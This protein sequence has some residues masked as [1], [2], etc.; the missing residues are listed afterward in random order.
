VRLDSHHHFWRYDAAE[1]GW[2]DAPMA[3]IRRDFLPD[4]LRVVAAGAGVDGAITVQARQSLAET[5][6]L[7]ELAAGDEF[8]RGVVGWV[9]LRSPMLSGQLERFA[10]EPKFRGVRHVVQGEPDEAFILGEAFNRGVA[11]LRAHRLVYDILIFARHL[12]NTLRFVDRHPDQVFV[13][14]HLAKP[15]IRGGG[16]GFWREQLRELARRPNVFCKASGL[17]T[18]ADY[19]TWTE[20]QLRP[21]FEAAVEAFGPR[22]LMAGSDWPVCLVACDYVRWWCILESWTA[23]WSD[24]ERARFFGGTAHEAYS[25]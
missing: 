17:V 25:L 2:I 3:A 1:F 24:A 21:Y 11:Q 22:R 5:E 19:H 9:D 10:A 14:D 12:P 4:D 13:V 8:I 6:W 20:A 18:E 23:S 16:F 15:D 7:L